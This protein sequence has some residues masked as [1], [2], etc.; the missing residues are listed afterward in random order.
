MERNS[1]DTMGVNNT[2]RILSAR[3][4]MELAEI[5]YYFYL[6][7]NEMQ[8]NGFT[9]VSA[10]ALLGFFIRAHL[11]KDDIQFYVE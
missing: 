6:F 5:E 2:E 9:V 10:G 1:A 11:Y 3:H 8:K 4:K 7:I